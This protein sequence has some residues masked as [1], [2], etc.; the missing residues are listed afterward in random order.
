M[1]A[2]E[3]VLNALTDE[4]KHVAEIMTETGL[5]APDVCT[6]LA[7]LEMAGKAHRMPGNKFMKAHGGS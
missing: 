7:L 2:R 5:S 4:P 6:S 1:T 3:A